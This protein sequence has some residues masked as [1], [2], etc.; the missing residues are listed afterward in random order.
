MKMESLDIRR[1][2]PIFLCA[3]LC[4]GPASAAVPQIINYQGNL[5][6]AGLLVTGTQSMVFR[7]YA[8]SSAA[9]PLWTSPPYSVSVA[10]GVFRVA[11]DLGSS[12]I[13]WQANTPWLELQVAGT[14]LSPREQLTS[15]PYA[16]NALLHSGKSYIT[17]ASAPASPNVGDLWFDMGSAV[18]K[19]WNGSAWTSTAGS[20]GASGGAAGGDLSGTYPNPTLAADRV[21]KAGDTMTGQLT[22]AGSTLTVTGNAF[23]VGTS[24]LVVVGGNVGIGTASPGALLEVGGLRVLNTGELQTTGVGRGP[25]SVAGNARGTG[26]VEL[27]VHRDNAAHV[28]SGDYS[29][30]GGGYDNA[31]SGWGSTVS[32]GGHNT[33]SGSNYSTVSGGD[34]N[35]AIS[36]SATVGGGLQNTASGNYATVG[37]GDFSTASGDYSTVGGGILNAASASNAAMAGGF[38]GMASGDSSAIGGGYLNQA[39]G[40]YSV[41][42]GGQNNTANA[43]YSFAAGRKSSATAQGAWAISDSQNAEFQVATANTFGARFAGGYLLTGG[44]LTATS[45]T[46]TASGPGQYSLSLSSGINAPAGTIKAGLFVGNGAGLYNVG[47]GGA[48]RVAKAGDT[49]TGQLTLA[50]STLT[51]TGN[52]FS[53]GTST[54][55]VV[56]GNVGIGTATPGSLLQVGG[57]T[58][59]KTGELQTTGVGLGTIAGN[60]RGAGAVD[61]EVS[62]GDAT[63]VASGDYSAIGGGEDNAASAQHATVGGGAYNTASAL[64]AT[65]G[66]GGVNTASMYATTVGG[67]VDNTASGDQSTVGGGQGNVASGGSATVGGGDFNT[68]SAGDATVGGGVG[69]RAK[70]WYSFVGGGLSNM[71]N[72]AYSAVPGG[73]ANTANADNSFAAGN[74]SSATA[75]GA[76]AISDSQDAEFRVSTANAFGARFAGGYQLTGGLVTLSGD[77]TSGLHAAT[78]RYVDGWNHPCG[79]P[80]DPADIMV[81]VGPWC[82]DKYE[83]SVWS[84]PTGGTQ[85]GA[86]SDNYPCSEDGQTC[87]TGASNPIYAR[88]VPGVLP[89]AYID[90]YRAQVACINAGKE[91]LPNAVW[92]AAASGTPDLSAGT[93]G[94]ACNISAAAIRNTDA[95]LSCIAS[96]GALNMV[97]NVSEWVADWGA[98]TPT[99][100]S[101]WPPGPGSG[102]NMAANGASTIAVVHRGGNSYSGGAAGVFAFNATNGPS[103]VSNAVGF[104]CGRRR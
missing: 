51:V 16:L 6:Q 103:A 104:R 90:W 76:W 71:A 4:A 93:A 21:R 25:G 38:W 41:V 96:Y 62:R 20:G 65:V 42:P 101:S 50:G 59:L 52:A 86:S 43:D 17:S 89:S 35:G 60:A 34:S 28:A 32:G 39:N 73:N 45:G 5:R 82:V 79:N 40:A 57:L 11:L 55:V 23:S 56:G 99:V 27:Q 36:Y 37:G 72:G 81:P 68:A 91:L 78:K 84:T 1:A 94:S 24:A 64:S 29:A 74:R 63:H 88:S 80:A 97:G 66:G 83:A 10:T 100:T 44:G 8:S 26:A 3:V 48:D 67:G 31:A 70:G 13:D 47:G 12:G 2:L 69:N 85:Y 14:V 54:L 53:V 49:M 75:Q 77:P 87:A 15:N 33:A 95:N 98:Y 9:T 22:L 18:L 19:Y 58:V 61:L 46:F 102:E 7:V 92:Q 30:I